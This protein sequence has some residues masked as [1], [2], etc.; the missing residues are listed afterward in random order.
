MDRVKL[1]DDTIQVT[2][3]NKGGKFF[4]KVSRIEAKSEINKFE[5]ELDINTDLYPVEKEGYYAM[6]LAS[7]VN[8]DGSPDFDIL[9]YQHEGSSEGLGSLLDQYQY[10][11][12]GKVFKYQIN[13]DKIS[14]YLSFGGLL[15]SIKGMLKDLK[16]LEIDSR[17]FLLLK[18]I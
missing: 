15:M 11:M 17:V 14:I 2:A 12:H 3:V 13:G 7:S 16:V 18:K 8:A 1:I 6:C 4:E 5:I 10:V 9:K